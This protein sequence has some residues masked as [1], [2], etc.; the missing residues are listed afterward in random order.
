MKTHHF[1][2]K[3]RITTN[4]SITNRHR[5]EESQGTRRNLRREVWNLGRKT[6]KS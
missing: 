6:W 1:I 3:V 2:E 5:E 4:V